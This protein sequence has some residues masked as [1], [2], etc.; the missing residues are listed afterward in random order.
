VSELA[1]L[2]DHVQGSIEAIEIAIVRDA[3]FDSS[4]HVDD[5][6]ALDDV[7]PRDAKASAALNTCNA[8]LDAALQLLLDAKT[9]ALLTKSAPK[10]VVL[11]GRS[12][13]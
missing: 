2:L 7:T 13:A 1:A 11:P 3:S 12:Q 4:D 6:V 8:S 5:V 9:S 10:L